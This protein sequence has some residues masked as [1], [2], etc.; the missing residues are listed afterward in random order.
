MSTPLIPFCLI[1]FNL[2]RVH[3]SYLVPYRVCTY[4]CNNSFPN[5]ITDLYQFCDTTYLNTKCVLYG[6]QSFTHMSD[7]ILFQNQSYPHGLYCSYKC[8]NTHL[9][10]LCLSNSVCPLLSPK[11]NCPMFI[12]PQWTENIQQCE[13]ART[14][15]HET[16]NNLQQLTSILN[17]NDQ[18]P[19]TSV[20][21]GFQTTLITNNID[22]LF[23]IFYDYFTYQCDIQLQPN[24]TIYYCNL[25]NILNVR[26]CATTNK[27]DIKYGINLI[28]NNIDYELEINQIFMLQSNE[29]EQYDTTLLPLYNGFVI[30]HAANIT[31]DISFNHSILIEFQHSHI[32]AIGYYTTFVSHDRCEEMNTLKFGIRTGTT[33]NP[34]SYDEI[35]MSFQC[36]GKKYQCKI[37]P[38]DPNGEQEL[39][40]DVKNM[41]RPTRTCDIIEDNI[42]FNECSFYLDNPFDDAVAVDAVILEIE[43][44]NLRYEFEYFCV[45]TNNLPYTESYDYVDSVCGSLG[46]YNVLRIDLQHITF[47]KINMLRIIMTNEIDISVAHKS[48]EC[49]PELERKYILVEEQKTYEEAEVYCQMSFGTHLATII[50]TNDLYNVAGLMKSFYSQVYIGLNDRDN[51]TVWKWL[52]GTSCNYVVETGLCIDDNHWAINTDNTEPNNDNNGEDCG[53]F[54]VAE[55]AF[56]DISCSIPKQFVCGYG[57]KNHSSSTTQIEIKETQIPER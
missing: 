48:S 40:C 3:G 30:T 32:D 22:V 19:S 23:T 15:N 20:I 35:T 57:L 26:Q 6:Y 12:Q 28:K 39:F 50:T 17:V 5:Y 34:H 16:R 52:D 56:N 53:V 44:R 18:T 38:N 25:D 4:T 8:N 1:V 10:N 51:E 24:K 13:Q 54:I 41:Y 46:G 29:I 43:E 9:P 37:Y 31:Q 36:H 55:V 11:D 2:I 21:A 14:N 7:A 47:L 45:N 33:F 49:L 42:D 27:L